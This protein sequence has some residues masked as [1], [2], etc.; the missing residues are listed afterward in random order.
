MTIFVSSV[1][2]KLGVVPPLPAPT[3][4]AQLGKGGASPARCIPPDQGNFVPLHPRRKAFRLSTPDQPSAAWIRASAVSRWTDNQGALPPDT[5]A[6]G[7]RARHHDQG[8]LPLGTRAGVSPRQNEQER[9]PCTPHHDRPI[10]TPAAELETLAGFLP[11]VI[12]WPEPA[13]RKK[14]NRRRRHVERFRTDDDEHA[15][16]ER[17]AR[18]AG[19][20][21]HAYSRMRTLGDPGPR[22]RRRAPVD[23]TALAHGLVAFNRQHSNY[24]QAVRALNRLALVAENDGWRECRGNCANCGR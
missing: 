6:S 9:G 5:P 1:V 11:E 21:V 16:L 8:A 12:T 10:A 14:P 18:D 23:A 4:G 7:F 19:L 20:T 24:N 22:A 3:S 15:E 13:A 17:R 2:S